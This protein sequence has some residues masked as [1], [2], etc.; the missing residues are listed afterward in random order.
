VPPGSYTVSPSFFS[1]AVYGAADIPLPGGGFPGCA[2]GRCLTAHISI[3]EIELDEEERDL[4]CTLAGI[5]MLTLGG[6]A[7]SPRRLQLLSVGGRYLFVDSAI[8]FPEKEIHD[9]YIGPDSL[10]LMHCMGDIAAGNENRA[11]DLCSG[12][13]IIGLFMAKTHANVVSTDISPA[14]LALIRVNAVLNGTE[15]KISIR[16]EALQETLAAAERFDLVAC[17]PPFVAFPPGFDR[18]L[19]AAGPDSDG[20]GYM[21]ILLEKVP[22]I[23]NDGGEGYFVADMPGD[24][25]GAYFFRELAA[26]SERGGCAVDAFVIDRVCAKL[27]AEAMEHFLRRMH[28]NSDAAE[29]KEPATRFILEELRASHY[30]L[31]IIKIK[32]GGNTGTRVLNQF[33]ARRFEDYF[34]GL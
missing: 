5:G 30:Y 6:D 27:Q 32:K 25:L 14:A 22:N 23:L 21:R 33:A 26:F 11:L 7:I 12:S 34:A 19:Y 24:G 3:P 18:P 10:L 2:I 31:T 17:N 4:A 16:K 9:I 15:E 8:H 1:H 13:G 29:T 28:P 20:L